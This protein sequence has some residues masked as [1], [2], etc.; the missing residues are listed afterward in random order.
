M[1]EVTC[2]SC[3]SANVV[4]RLMVN[5]IMLEYCKSCGAFWEAE[6]RECTASKA[7]DNCAWRPGSPER[8]DT[9]KWAA[10]MADFKR[11]AT[12]Y[13]HKRVPCQVDASG[14]SFA[15]LVEVQG[16]R[17]VCTNAPICAGWLA[18]KLGQIYARPREAVS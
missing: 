9:A 15:H 16:N 4:H 12:F 6:L 3:E 1:A 14:Y 18:W 11:G 5:G 10:M 17:K 7:C 2:P 13:C 8:A